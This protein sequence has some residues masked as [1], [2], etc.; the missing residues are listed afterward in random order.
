[1]KPLL[2]DMCRVTPVDGL[3][4]REMQDELAAIYIYTAGR[5]QKTKYRGGGEKLAT[6]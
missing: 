1:M 4:S 2:Q 3:E 5:V 6:S